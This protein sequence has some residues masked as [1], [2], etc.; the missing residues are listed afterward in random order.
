MPIHTVTLD[1]PLLLMINLKYCR[2]P[3]GVIIHRPIRAEGA[4]FAGKIQK[5]LEG[6]LD[7]GTTED[8]STVLL[9]DT[10]GQRLI[11]NIDNTE[12]KAGQR[13]ITIYCPYWIVNA[14]Q[15]TIR[16]REEGSRSL[17]A[18]SVTAQLDGSKTVTLSPLL[19]EKQDD[20][21]HSGE[22]FDKRYGRVGEDID[23]SVYSSKLSSG[24]T[25]PGT[26]GI[27]HSSNSKEFA[28][29]NILHDKM[30]NMSFEDIVE[31]S[32]MFN[33]SDNARGLIGKKRVSIQMDES[34]WSRPFSLDTIGVNQVV[35]V[36]S[37]DYGLFEVGFK[38]KAAQVRIH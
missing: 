37:H 20:S 38:I 10:V 23:S 35:S 27:I 19:N 26:K 22:K 16:I 9:T 5:T 8:V 33:F 30:A 24:A 17:P 28:Y 13:H 18:G 31:L 7:E 11:L 4:T 2:T 6:F 12:G 1:E 32:Y 14:C 25:F 29:D 21:R 15:Y 36:E 34:S 3:D